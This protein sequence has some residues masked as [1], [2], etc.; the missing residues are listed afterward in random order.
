[1]VFGDG[2]SNGVQPCISLQ[3]PANSYSRAKAMQIHHGR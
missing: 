3:S 2:E 1:M